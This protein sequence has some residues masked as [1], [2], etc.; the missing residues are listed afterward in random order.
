MKS[1]YILG[2]SG[3]GGYTH[4]NSVAILRDGKVMFASSEERY[5][6]VKHDGAIPIKAVK[7]AMSYL[8]IK[9]SEINTIA[10]GFPKRNISSIFSHKHALDILPFIF[11]ILVN[12]NVKLLFDF[13][14]AVQLL[15]K[16]SKER[17][18]GFIENKKVI[19][20]DHHLSHAASAYFTSGFDKCLSIAID[21]FGT[22]TNGEIRSGA[23]FACQKG[24]LR[25]VHSIPIYAS[26]GC[27][28][29]SVTY[30]L[31]FKP[32]DGEGKTMGLAAYG[33]P[34]KT[35]RL[36]RPYCPELKNGEWQKSKE[37]LA[38]LIPTVPTHLK[39]FNSSGFG[40]FLNSQLKENKPEDVAAGAQKLLE[41]EL[42]KLVKYLL[43]KYPGYKNICLSGGVFL[44][45]KANKKIMEI[46]G[47]ENIFVHPNAGD[48]GCALGAAFMVTEKKKLEKIINKPLVNAALGEDF[49]TM[50]IRSALKKYENKIT[51]KRKKNIT[52]YTS[53]QIVNGKVIGWF[54]GRSE[55]GPRA[56]GFRS[57]LADPRK[58][59]TK[60]RINHVLKKRDWF[61]PFA[62]SILEEEGGNYFKNFKPSPF[63]TMTFDIVKGKEK[64][65][66]AALH[67]DNTARPNSVN[68]Y[69][70][71]LYYSLLRHFYKKTK[72]PILLNTSFNRHG[73]PIVNS[74]EDAIDHLIMGA[75]DELVIGNFAVSPTN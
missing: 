52:E 30:M 58:L 6:R 11:S 27:F 65:F 7:S 32:G 68:K 40:V 69:N 17:K 28:F 64:K 71:P 12:R 5:S 70:N 26:L 59:E 72:L 22:K 20:V 66:P 34:R 29:H 56:L 4:D 44:N 16:I 53:Q 62:P 33:N 2:I 38:G 9:Q 50:Q 46:D 43:K 24:S 14:S 41:D 13:V 37:W 18:I 49:S 74:P 21:G 75:V 47:I 1:K 57:V 54:Q 67:V 10:V 73:L 55:W 45:V 35:Y 60:E 39:M 25:E 48:G 63:M 8:K 61:M 19:Y 23:V 42:V 51:Y 36:I 31:G 15:S 3:I